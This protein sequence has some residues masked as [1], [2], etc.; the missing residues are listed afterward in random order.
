MEHFN[1]SEFA[2]KCGCGFDV[3]DFE[4]AEV[5]DLLRDHFDAPVYVHSGCRCKIHNAAIGGKPN[6]QHQLGKAADI[7]VAHISPEIVSQYLLSRYKDRYGIGR[8]VRFTHID[9][10][11]K[12]ARW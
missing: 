12:R 5:L 11:T 7:V 8:Y 1:R 6:S 3:V 9:V 10:R 2:C 4:L